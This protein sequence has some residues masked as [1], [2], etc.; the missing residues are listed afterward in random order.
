M[1]TPDNASRYL[2]G[3]DH[4]LPNTW[5]PAHSGCLR[6]ASYWSPRPRLSTPSRTSLKRKVGGMQR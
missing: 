1:K 2:A 6:L 4:A 3:G 5:S